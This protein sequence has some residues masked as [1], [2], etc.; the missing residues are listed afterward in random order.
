MA[1]AKARTDDAYNRD[2]LLAWHVGL[3]SRLKDLGNPAKWF[4]GDREEKTQP[5]TTAQHVTLAKI[6]A[7]MGG[8]FTTRA[9]REA[10][11][12]PKG[13]KPPGA[14]YRTSHG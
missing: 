13:T 12:R 8:K 5:Q 11:K 9:Q 14:K 4:T 7:E 3:F 10:A 2:V 1:I 6:L